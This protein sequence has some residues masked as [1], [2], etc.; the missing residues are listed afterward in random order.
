MAPA[1]DIMYGHGCN[2]D[3]LLSVIMLSIRHAVT[4]LKDKQPDRVLHLSGYT[5]R[6]RLGFS[7]KFQLKT[8]LYNFVLLLKSFFAKGL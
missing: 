3:C 5:Y 2:H 6:T 1:I 8:T 4:R 7:S